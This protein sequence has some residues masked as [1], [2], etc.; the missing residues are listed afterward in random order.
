MCF[1]IF[2]YST[3]TD[4]ICFFIINVSTTY[5]RDLRNINAILAKYTLEQKI[6]AYHKNYSEDARKNSFAYR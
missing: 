2:E 1:S 5:V 3:T 6:C 4:R